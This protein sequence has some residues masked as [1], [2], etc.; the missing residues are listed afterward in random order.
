MGKCGRLKADPRVSPPPW[1]C[2]HSGALTF[3]R[4]HARLGRP[5]G[6]AG[7]GRWKMH[8]RATPWR[9]LAAACRIARKGQRE[10]RRPRF[11]AKS[12][13]DYFAIFGRGGLEFFNTRGSDGIF[14]FFCERVTPPCGPW[15]PCLP[16]R[17]SVAIVTEVRLGHR[18]A[19]MAREG[20]PM[21]HPKARG[22]CENRLFFID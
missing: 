18:S 13:L 3:S 7:R 19:A 2:D 9:R 12:E 4:P 8:T 6:G 22:G 15:R 5:A 10:R 20:R 17:T 21:A 16:R 1:R 14:F 11:E